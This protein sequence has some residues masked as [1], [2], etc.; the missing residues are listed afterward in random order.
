MINIKKNMSCIMFDAII[1][2]AKIEKLDHSAMNKHT[3]GV[4]F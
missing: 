2:S 3:V 4:D 1:K